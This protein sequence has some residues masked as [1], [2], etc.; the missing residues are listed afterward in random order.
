MRHWFQIVLAGAAVLLAAPLPAQ[1]PEDRYVEFFFKLREA[2]GFEK[3]GDVLGAYNGYGQALALLEDIARSSPE[4][5]KDVVDF[6]LKFCRGKLKELE[7]LAKRQRSDFPESVQVPSAPPPPMFDKLPAP[8]PLP[9][10]PTPAPGPAPAPPGI[11]AGVLPTPRNEAELAQVRQYAEGLKRELD[12]TRSELDLAKAQLDEVRKERADM[13]NRIVELGRMA[14]QSQG[15]SDPAQ[16]ESMAAENRLLQ[17]KLRGLEAQINERLA[18]NAQ[19]EQAF[20]DMRAKVE[21]ARKQLDVARQEKEGY[22]AQVAQLQTQLKDLQKKAVHMEGATNPDALRQENAMLRSVAQRQLAE[23]SR[24][25]DIGRQL[26]DAIRQ[27]EVKPA[28]L[29]ETIAL[30]ADAS[31]SLTPEEQAAIGTA[32][33]AESAPPMAQP[34]EPP[35]PPQVSEPIPDARGGAR[36][37]MAAVPG[38]SETMPPTPVPVVPSPAAVP[39]AA[40]AAMPATA[41]TQESAPVPTP[42]MIDPNA[43]PVPEPAATVPLVPPVT[44]EPMPVLAGK[45]FPEIPSFPS[46]EAPSAPAPAPQPEPSSAMPV[47]VVAAPAPMEAAPVAAEVPTPMPAV[48]APAPAP[49]EPAPVAAVPTVPAPP[50]EAMPMP[51][52]VPAPVPAPSDALPSAPAVIATQP[53]A[54]IPAPAAPTPGTPAMAQ[55][56]AK[57]GDKK[58]GVP[59]ASPVAIPPDMQAVVDEAGQL[60]AR[61]MYDEAAAK[62]EQV[63]ERYPK[64]VYALSNLAVVRFQ[65]RKLNEAE[66]YLK[67]AIAILPDDDFSHSI[68]GIVYF[69]DQRYDEALSELQRAEQLNPNDAR[70]QK[71]LG[72]TYKEKGLPAES[73]RALARARAIDPNL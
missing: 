5:K 52:P 29:E 13:E 22:A 37:E 27:M 36:I 65:Q 11:G 54:S 55:P 21:D 26:M 40:P 53:G 39:E 6:R 57:G 66:I 42:A 43:L 60:F 18:A 19:M 69:L 72:L 32:P 61:G 20:S 64:N 48:A 31:M 38:P 10:A 4:W 14:K 71:Y 47:Q 56:E 1:T 44:G 2:E 17:D 24:R 70:T 16:M 25:A 8:E 33:A 49:M 51:E 41:T 45:A 23:H 30:L 73:E 12:L 34:V 15:A 58:A 28:G 35:A 50:G 63:L 67:Q 7:P 9:G 62:Y 68:L 46:V 59:G 3:Q